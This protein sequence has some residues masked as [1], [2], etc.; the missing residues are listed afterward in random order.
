MKLIFSKNG[1]NEIGL[2]LQKGTVIEDFSYTEMVRQLIDEN[3]F[4]D[5]D[6]GT[7]TPEEQQKI[8]SMLDK[9]SDVFKED[10]EEKDE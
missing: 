5:T 8:N 1:N 3:K 4:E 7:L 2:K 6:Y 10:E 9:I